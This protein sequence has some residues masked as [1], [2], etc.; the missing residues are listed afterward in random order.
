MCG[1]YT[2]K[3]ILL[4][5]FSGTG[6]VGKVFREA[7]WDV[8]SVDLNP[9]CNP[10]IVAD[11]YQLELADVLAS[12]P[13]DASGSPICIDLL[14]ASPVCTHYSCARSHAAKERD[15]EGS[16]RLVRRVLELAD[17]LACPYFMENPY[18]GLLRK[19]AVVGGLTYRVVDY[20]RYGFRY[21]KRTCIWTDT[22]WVP[23]QPLCKFDCPSAAGKG[24]H[25]AQA[26]K[27]P[28]GPCFTRDELYRV[29]PDLC[30]ELLAWATS[31]LALS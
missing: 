9:K 31:A 16:D 10:T 29:P 19:R 20:C 5:L 25:S 7:G 1:A 15:L 17:A 13:P 4:E 22:D 14:W 2:L 24:R 26:Q 8:I 12:R 21:R 3:M 28:P 27:G 18:S 11:V 30:S 23:V 6:S